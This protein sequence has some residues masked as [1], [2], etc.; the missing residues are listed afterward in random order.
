MKKIGSK[1][2]VK[3]KMARE[4][5]G[6]TQTEL[7]KRLNKTKSYMS[8]LETGRAGYSIHTLEPIAKMLDVDISYFYRW[9][10]ESTVNDKPSTVNDENVHYNTLENNLDKIHNLLSEHPDVQ[11]KVLSYL[12]SYYE[13]GKNSL[14][15][16]GGLIDSL[17]PDEIERIMP[18]F[19]KRLRAG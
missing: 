17:G 16:I 1:I 10:F 9:D 11:Q 18:A 15:R 6:W 4:K 2:G 3:L 19:I 5:K 12:E 14:T 13:G 7:A 8:N